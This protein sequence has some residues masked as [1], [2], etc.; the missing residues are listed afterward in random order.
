[1]C[2]F[3]MSLPKTS[4]ADTTTVRRCGEI[5]HETW[6]LLH[7]W[8]R[9]KNA[10]LPAKATPR[11]SAEPELEVLVH[12]F[13]DSTINAAV[14]YWHDPTLRSGWTTHHDVAVSVKDALDV[15][16]IEIASP[17]RVLAR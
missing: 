8:Q 5:A 4:P 7:Q 11:V 1:M 6:V 13:V 12:E 3:S 15:N 10:I 17:Q 14:R 9:A 2:P 16:G